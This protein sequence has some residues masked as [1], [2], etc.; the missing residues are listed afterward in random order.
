MCVKGC[1]LDV[2][3]CVRSGNGALAG[4]S[5]TRTTVALRDLEGGA[6]CDTGSGACASNASHGV[7]QAGEA[8]TTT[9]D[10]AAPMSCWQSAVFS[11]DREG[12][13]FC[14]QLCGPTAAAGAD[15][16]C[17]AGF[18]CQ[19]GFMLGFPG[20]PLGPVN[21]GVGFLVEDA[22]GDVVE[23]G[24]MCFPTCADPTTCTGFA[25]TSCGAADEDIFSLLSPERVTWNQVPMCLLTA[26]R[27]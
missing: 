6:V 8:C 17:A 22:A 21:D 3:D 16:A 5:T 20:D 13:G 27:Q 14:G 9:T 1:T 11:L 23:R 4:A 10:C 18:A 2:P 7:R 25:G 26:L 15:G 24:G 12:L 19:A